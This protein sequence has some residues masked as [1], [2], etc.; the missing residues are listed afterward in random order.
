MIYSLSRDGAMPLSSYWYKMDALVGGP[1]RSVWLAVILAFILGKYS[2]LE[3]CAE[4]QLHHV[5]LSTHSS[6][7]FLLSDTQYSCLR[8]FNILHRSV[9]NFLTIGI[10]T[11]VPPPPPPSHRSTLNLL[12]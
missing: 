4:Y 11:P 3:L 9:H 1:V 10:L 2:L 8:L 5:I 7:P 12:R 6:C